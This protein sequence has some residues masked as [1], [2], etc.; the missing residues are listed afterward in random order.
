[1]GVIESRFTETHFA[2]VVH[3]KDVFLFGLA[4][5]IANRA[6]AWEFADSVQS[7]ADVL[8]VGASS[9]RRQLHLLREIGWLRCRPSP[10]YAPSVY[11]IDRRLI[12]NAPDARRDACAHARSIDGTFAAKLTIKRGRKR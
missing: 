8:G 9:A 10:G 2:R 7:I 6:H 3:S 4:L 12:E 5:L 1:M 11:V